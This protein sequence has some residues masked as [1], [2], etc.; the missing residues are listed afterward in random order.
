MLAHLQNELEPLEHLTV[1]E[2]LNS[3]YNHFRRAK[4]EQFAKYDTSY[5]VQLRKLEE[6]GALQRKEKGIQQRAA[7]PRRISISTLGADACAV[8]L[9]LVCLE[10]SNFRTRKSRM[11]NLFMQSTFLFLLGSKNRK[12]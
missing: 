3:F 7:S 2:N 12:G 5:R 6:I 1:C 4:G 9:L 8:A 11:I 10:V